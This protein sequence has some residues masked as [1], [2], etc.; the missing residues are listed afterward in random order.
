MPLFRALGFG[1]LILIMKILIPEV[2]SEG[3]KTAV[4]ILRGTQLSVA[5]ATQMV[6]SVRVA[7]LP[8]QIRALPPFALP[9]APT[10]TAFINEP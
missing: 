9:Q 3:E 2:L 4:M 10:I 6:G 7:S 5:T 8:N 1:V